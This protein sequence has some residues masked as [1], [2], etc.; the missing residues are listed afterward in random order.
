MKTTKYLLLA[1][2]AGSLLAGCSNKSDPAASGNV[3]IAISATTTNGKTSFGGRLSTDGS[4]DVLVNIKEIEFEFDHDDDHF[5]KD[6]SFNDEDEVELKGPFIVD[7]L[8]ADQFVDQVITTVKLP[9]AKYEK[10]SFKL[11]PSSENGDLKGKSILI[12]GKIDEVNFVFSSS[13]KAKFGARFVE[14]D[15]SMIATG[16]ALKVAIKF[17]LDKVLNIANG[18]DLMKLKDLNKDGVISISDDPKDPDKNQF[19]A[20]VIFKL[21]QRHAHCEK[22]KS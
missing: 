22:R 2:F 19:I 18:I 16:D 17:E 15:S 5:K 11:S 4:R 3:S 12:K 14:A 13:A 7:L 9:N 21:L 1:L 6:S 8:N 20:Q 10:V